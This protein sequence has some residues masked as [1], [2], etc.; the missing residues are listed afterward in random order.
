MLLPGSSETGLAIRKAISQ[1]PRTAILILGYSIFY[2]MPHSAQIISL[3]TH[4][5]T[6]ERALFQ[7]KNSGPQRAGRIL[8]GHPSSPKGQGRC[9]LK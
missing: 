8:A 9:T 2:T 3:I 7:F 5:S 6:E 4:V 1:S